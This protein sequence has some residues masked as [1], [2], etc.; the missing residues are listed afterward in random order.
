MPTPR[1]T[2]KTVGPSRWIDGGASGS[3]LMGIASSLPAGQT[4]CFS[5]GVLTSVRAAR[6][7]SS[8]VNNL[9]RTGCLR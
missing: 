9:Q 4:R 6:F 1:A 2:R 7:G 3:F 8:T 5:G